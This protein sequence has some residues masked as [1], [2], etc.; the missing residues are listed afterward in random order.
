VIEALGVQGKET[1]TAYRY[2]TLGNLIQVTAAVGMPE[3]NVTNVSY[4]SLMKKRAM[5]DPDM[6]G[7][8]YEYDKMG[9]LTRQIDAKNQTITFA[10]DGLNRLT[11]KTYPTNSVTFT[12]DDPSVPYSWGKLTKISYQPS[13]EDLREDRILEYDLMQ[14]LT[15]SQKTIGSQS[16]T[17][18][19]SYDS[20]GRVISV[21]YLAGTGSEKTYSYEYDTTGDLLYVK[22]NASGNHLVDYSDFTALGQQKIATFPKPNNVS[23]KSTYT[24]D[25]QTARLKTLMTQ[26]LLGANP[27]DTYQNLDYQQFDGRGNLITLA[28]AS[29]GITHSYTYDPLNRLLTANGA[30]TNAYSQSFQYDRIGNITYKSDF[31]TYTYDYSNKPHAVKS[32]VTDRPVYSDPIL[33]IT[34][35]YDNKPEYVKKSGSNYVQFTYDGNGQ[36]VKKYNFTTGQTTLYFGGLY[37]VRGG[38]GIIHVFAGSQR[39]A[40]VFPDGRTQ[41]YHSNHLG[42]SSVITDGNGDRKEKIEYFPFGE[43]RAVGNTNGTYDFDPTFPDVYYTFTGQEDD[44]DLGF[45]NY[46]ARLY[47]PVLGRFISPDS[48]VQ[49]PDDPQTLNRYSYARNNPLIYTDPS[50]NWFI[51]DDII[52]SVLIAIGVGEEAAGTIG[53]ITACAVV[54]AGLG[55][56][57]SAITGGDIGMGALTGAIS[58]VLFYGAGSL[59][60]PLTEGVSDLAKVAITAGIHMATGAAS[61]AI[62]SAIT[63]GNIG[64]GALTGAVGAGIGAVT[65]GALTYFGVG[66][67]QFGYQ[68]VARTVTG[69]IAGGVVSS[70]YGGNFWQGFAQGVATAAAG[71]LFNESMPSHQQKVPWYVRLFWNPSGDVYCGWYWVRTGITLPPTPALRIGW[72]WDV[73]VFWQNEFS[74]HQ[75]GHWFWEFGN[76][77]YYWG[78]EK[79]DLVVSTTGRA[80]IAGAI[81]ETDVPYPPANPYPRRP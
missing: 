79:G 50:G 77:P 32:V 24:Y 67:D 31:G 49:A 35:N 42:S 58:G 46:G 56:A 1:A 13:G 61:G 74:C 63:G 25:P 60:G 28:D 76:H 26:K 15:K 57:T 80:Y 52:I 65:G 37:E 36:R 70:I 69:G 55:A 12:Y 68:L 21:K 39:V 16:V 23:V 18:Q 2:D 54:G 11:Q 22:D 6:G 78:Y 59:A 62:N 75:E 4:D 19:K 7:W 27:T 45:Y 44:D 48:I 73:E 14:R 17:F 71:F 8:S 33:D 43:Y 64:V 29:N 10:Y 34:Y 81:I 47:D 40:S 30:G 9:N 53:T 41:F 51:I 20:A 5:T 66:N 3:Q 72:A 38:V